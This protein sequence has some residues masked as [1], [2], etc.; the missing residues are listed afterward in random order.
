MAITIESPITGQTL[1]DGNPSYCYLFEPKP[2]R[3]LDSNTGTTKVFITINL[4]NTGNKT[5]VVSTLTNYVELDYVAGGVSVDLAEVMRQHIDLDV[6]KFSSINEM[7]GQD[8]GDTSFLPSRFYDFRITTNATST[9]TSITF[10]PI[11]GGRDYHDFTPSLPDN[12]SVASEFDLLTTEEYNTIMLKWGSPNNPR[13]NLQ[14]LTNTDLRSDLEGQG[15][16]TCNPKGGMLYWKSRYGGL[17]FWGMDLVR[18]TNSSS[19]T[20]NLETG[21][22]DYTDSG[23]IHVPANY[24]GKTHSYSYSLKALGLTVNELEA[25]SGINFSPAIYYRKTPTS[26]LELMRLSSATAPIDNLINGGDFSV[27]LQSISN[28]KIKTR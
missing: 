22:L 19:Y 7:S 8:A 5:E 14:N 9:V 17:V 6:Y 16:E 3:I 11:I 2:I 24:T 26:R 20:G 12:Y 18:K 4:I 28:T 15:G 25:V 10:L 27:T 13:I 23:R 21:L 1:T